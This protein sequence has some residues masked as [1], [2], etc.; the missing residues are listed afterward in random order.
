MASQARMVVEMV[1]THVQELFD[2][3]NDHTSAPPFEISITRTLQELCR[4]M[5]DEQVTSRM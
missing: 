3:R 1:L 2:S 5:G 4:D